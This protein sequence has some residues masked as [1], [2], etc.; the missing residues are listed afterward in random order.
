MLILRPKLIILVTTVTAVTSGLFTLL[1]QSPTPTAS[2]TTANNP[3][4]TNSPSPALS[5]TPKVVALEGNLELD[6]LIRVEVEHLNEWALKNDATK[7]VPYLNGLAIHGNYPAEIHA[8]Q[9]N[10]QF[11]LQSTSESRKVWINLLVAPD[12][13]HKTVALTDGIDQ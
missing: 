6:D 13:T 12:R 1:A 2:P 10:L 9:N 4:P 3:M 7:L 5:M 11:H 8:S